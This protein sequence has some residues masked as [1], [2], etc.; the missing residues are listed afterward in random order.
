MPRAPRQVCV[1]QLDEWCAHHCGRTD[2]I[3][4]DNNTQ[5]RPYAFGAAPDLPLPLKVDCGLLGGK[6]TRTNLR[7]ALQNCKDAS[8]T[9]A[10]HASSHADMFMCKSSAAD[11]DES[12][13]ASLAK[14]EQVAA[15]VKINF[16][17]L[18]R[19]GAEYLERNLNCLADLGTSFA[20]WT[21]YYVENDS[22][23]DTRRLLDSF[24]HRFPRRI[25]GEQLNGVSAQPSAFLCP[26]FRKHM[27]CQARGSLLAT[28]RERLLRL[29]LASTAQIEPRAVTRSASASRRAET[30][31]L[32]L[33]IDF[34][35]F[36]RAAYL[37][38]FATAQRLRAAA[39]FGS[40]VFKS[41]G[42]SLAAY[43]LG[44]V[45]PRRG[46]A[47][48]LACGHRVSRQKPEYHW[49]RE[50]RQRHLCECGG[51]APS[52]KGAGFAGGA[53]RAPLLLRV[54]TPRDTQLPRW[55]APRS[56]L[57][58]PRRL[59]TA[60]GGL[61]DARALGLRRLWNLLVGG[62]SGGTRR[63]EAVGGRLQ[64]FLRRSLEQR[65]APCLRRRACRFQHRVG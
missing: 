9:N 30:V 52:N 41:A 49:H 13:S 21:I 62:A 15:H 65:R 22:A 35:A 57:Q 1:E 58:T 16:A 7:L 12:P 20:T 23:D 43:D 18:V 10:L 24:G 45:I 47:S 17:F 28:L 56:G 51:H 64:H 27:N 5:C 36:S 25:F 60:A 32:M 55:F 33:D 61:H 31:L 38:A 63:A 39:F 14:A 46:P 2:L 37:R 53:A 6:P 8:A 19:D 26:P 42:G 3:A 48:S 40:S 29:V 4:S 54:P 44:A 50:V 11:D 59:R 34:V